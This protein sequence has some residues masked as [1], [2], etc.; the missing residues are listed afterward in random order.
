MNIP[1]YWHTPLLIIK[2]QKT[3]REFKMSKD[4]LGKLPLLLS[5]TNLTSYWLISAYHFTGL[6][7]IN[8]EHILNNVVYNQ[9][10]AREK[11]ERVP[12]KMNRLNLTKLLDET[13]TF[14]MKWDRSDITR[15]T[16]QFLNNNT[17]FHMNL[18]FKDLSVQIILLTRYKFWKNYQIK[19]LVKWW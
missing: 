18:M 19:I 11:I 17:I 9:S 2:F 6:L 15:L 10:Q 12:N 3:R 1:I 7:W 5:K 4:S 13:F 16:R 14:V 8:L